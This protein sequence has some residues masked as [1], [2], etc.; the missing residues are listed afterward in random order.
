M[1][2]RRKSYQTAVNIASPGKMDGTAV[3]HGGVLDECTLFR[4]DFSA[5][6]RTYSG[7]IGHRRILFEQTIVYLGLQASIQVNCGGIIR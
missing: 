1:A 4:V 7:G 6:I 5:I 2:D 3:I